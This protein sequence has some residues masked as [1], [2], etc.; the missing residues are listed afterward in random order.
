MS[1]YIER[2]GNVWTLMH[3]FDVVMISSL[4]TAKNVGELRRDPD[5]IRGSDILFRNSYV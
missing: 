2:N 3:V 5:N 1:R 4:L